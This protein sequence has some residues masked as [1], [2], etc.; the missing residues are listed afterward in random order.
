MS[1]RVLISQSKPSDPNSSYYKLAD[2]FNLDISFVPFNTIDPVDIKEFRKQKIN[3]NEYTA[4]VFVSRNSIDHFYRVWKELK[5]P[6]PDGMKYFCLTEL[7]ANYLQKYIVPKKRKI[8]VGKRNLSELFEQFSKQNEEK[9]LLVSSQN[10]KREIAKYFSENGIKYSEVSF[11]HV[12][13][14]DLSG[15]KLQEFDIIGFF[16]PSDVKS[17][18]HNFPGFKQKKTLLACFGPSTILAAKEAGL[19]V[20]IK[21]PSSEALSMTDALNLFFKTAN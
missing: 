9:Y 5:I 17:L 16:S 20:N 1:R 11:F 4:I 15:I 18:Y 13:P 14:N 21:A 8:F 6:V 7:V 12:T 10:P 3:I 2:K 19:T